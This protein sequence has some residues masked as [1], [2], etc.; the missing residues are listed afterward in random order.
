MNSNHVLDVLK[1][2]FMTFKRLSQ[3]YDKYFMT[4][5]QTASE[6]HNKMSF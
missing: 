5:E 1:Q 4:K 3:I 6:A 2:V